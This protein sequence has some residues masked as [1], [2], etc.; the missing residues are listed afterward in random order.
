MTRRELEWISRSGKT[1]QD[2]AAS[3]AKKS[4]KIFPF[5]GGRGGR[6]EGGK[7]EER[8]GIRSIETERKSVGPG[9]GKEES[10]I[11]RQA[12]RRRLLVRQP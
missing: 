12:G 10:E 11:E 4:L 1:E 8:K 5:R 9:G 2:E 3:Q 6:R 7:G